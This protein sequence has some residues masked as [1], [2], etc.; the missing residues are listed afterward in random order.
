MRR[1]VVPLPSKPADGAPLQDPAQPS[2]F[3]EIFP[4]GQPAR[5]AFDG[6]V[7][8]P[9]PPMDIW[10]VDTTF[11]AASL[12]PD[13]AAALYALLHR[14]GG[15]KGVVRQCEFP[16]GTDA[17]REVLGRCLTGKREF[18]EPTAWIRDGGKEEL[19]VL[20]GLGVKE[21]GFG[22]PCSDRAIYLERHLT[23]KEAAHRHLEIV[24]HLLAAGVVPRVHLEDATRADLFGFLV[25]FSRTLME[26]ARE[27]EVPVKLRLCDSLGL[28]VP[29]EGAAPP[30][31]VQRL[32]Q[33]LSE[34]AEV[35]SEWLEWESGNACPRAIPNAAGA[36]MSGVSACAGA[37]QGLGGAADLQALLAEVAGLKGELNGL[38]LEAATEAAALLRTAVPP[39]P[40]VAAR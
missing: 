18:P 29:Y 16:V 25:P 26:R 15:P 31:A 2:L 24:D 1:I 33:A 39:A 21:A 7:V 14:L 40:A 22:A 34:E 5:V 23:R 9:N 13:A 3:P 28:G 17:E 8:A 32:V 10:A 27:A 19:R 20:A 30:R 36:W 4:D 12:P 11:R 37:L 35:P 38:K 6:R